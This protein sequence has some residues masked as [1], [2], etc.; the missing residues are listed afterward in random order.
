[1]PI[2][3]L[4]LI[5]VGLGVG[6]FF[7]VKYMAVIAT[8]TAIIIS[9]ITVIILASV[10]MGTSYCLQKLGHYP[11]KAKQAYQQVESDLNQ[12]AGD[13][14]EIRLQLDDIAPYLR[15]MEFLRFARQN[16][17]AAN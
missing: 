17:K 3:L 14:T 9:G 7:T 1:M 16:R 13:L 15:D 12:I 8:V 5:G 2:L 11:R 6:L 10:W 4:L